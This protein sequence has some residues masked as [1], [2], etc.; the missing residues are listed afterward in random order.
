ML[1]NLE[2]NNEQKEALLAAYRLISQNKW[3][4]DK[5]LQTVARAACRYAVNVTDNID[6]AWMK[7]YYEKCKCGN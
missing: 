6:W 2:E 1:I 3:I 7:I 5:D 4:M